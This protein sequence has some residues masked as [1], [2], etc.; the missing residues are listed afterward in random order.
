MVNFGRRLWI[1]PQRR[2]R[3]FGSR[4]AATS[5]EVDVIQCAI[6]RSLDLWTK[7]Q[8]SIPARPTKLLP[9]V[10]GWARASEGGE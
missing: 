6:R 3:S 7:R 8:S 5:D 4:A 2:K 9:C 1:I 10:N